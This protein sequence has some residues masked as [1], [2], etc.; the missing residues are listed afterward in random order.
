[1]MKNLQVY[2]YCRSDPGEGEETIDRQKAKL[3]AYAKD[4]GWTIVGWYIDRNIDGKTPDRPE[5]NRLKAD[6]ADMTNP[7]V[8]MEKF[9]TWF[10]RSNPDDFSVPFLAYVTEAN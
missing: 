4:K 7:A 1:M 8:I 6:T 10:S 5:M 2:A 3:E 9:A